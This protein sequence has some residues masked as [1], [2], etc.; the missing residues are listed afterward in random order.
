M[1]FPAPPQS[2]SAVRRAGKAIA[3]RI[4]TPADIELVDQWR[5]AHGY[6]LNTFKVWLRD[7]VKK[8]SPNAEFAQRLKRRNT[9]VDKLR[10]KTPAGDPLIRDVTAMQDFAGCRLIFDT[11]EELRDFEE[12]LLSRDVLS[13]V[14]TH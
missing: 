8:R 13:R 1:A 14:Q 5:A 7:K 2:K 9:V 3:E 10:R 11:V 4:E 12:Y 6:V